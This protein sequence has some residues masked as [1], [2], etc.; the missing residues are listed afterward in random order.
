M[1]YNYLYAIGINSRTLALLSYDIGHMSGRDK[2]YRFF[3]KEIFSHPLAI[4][5]INGEQA[6]GYNYPH[7]IILELLYQFGI[8]LG[9]LIIAAIIARAV[10]TLKASHINKDAKQQLEV[11]FLCASLPGLM[12]SGT[13]WTQA[14]FW[15]WLAV[16]KKRLN[17]YPNVRRG[18]I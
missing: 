17:G 4:H 3:L 10:K 7:N 14:N 13:L 8:V 11:I 12:I 18:K 2:L 6:L 5:G 1:L 15:I 9:G 16:S